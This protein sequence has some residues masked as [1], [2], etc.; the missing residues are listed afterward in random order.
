MAAVRRL[1]GSEHLT[2]AF[3]TE[4]PTY[5]LD[6][7]TRA[8]LA[9]ATKLTD[10]PSAIEDGDVDALRSAGWSERG[11][12]DATALISY[13]NFTGRMEAAAGLPPDEVPPNLPAKEARTDRRGSSTLERGLEP[14]P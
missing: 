12:W 8:L 7:K 5:D 3:A 4:W 10:A 14:S 2:F 1:T 9:Y 13:F 6:V 11:I